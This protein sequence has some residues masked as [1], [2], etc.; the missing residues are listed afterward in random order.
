MRENPENEPVFPNPFRTGRVGSAWDAQDAVNDVTSIHQ[1]V[2]DACLD[3][4]DHVRR[5]N[6][7]SGFLMS[8][9]PGSGKTHMIRRLRE[10]L[11]AHLSE[12]DLSELKQIFAYVR[13]D[14]TAQGIARHVRSRVAGDLLRKSER[15]ASPFELMVIARLM[16]MEGSDG[17]L[18]HWW[19]YLLDT[20][21]RDIDEL[22]TDF[23][24]AAG[25]TSNFTRILIHLVRR[26]HRLD[27]AAWL[28]G[29]SLSQQAY[30]RLEIAPA[31]DDDAENEALGVLRDFTRLAGSKLPLVLCFDQVEALQTR[32]DDQQAVFA[33]G[34]LICN[35]H[36]AN[37]NLVIISCM[38]SSLF[39]QFC[40]VMPRYQLD[41]V[42][43]YRAMSL[44]PLREAEARRLLVT[45]LGSMRSVAG[46]P[47]HD[48][49]LWPLET[50]DLRDLVGELGT[51]PRELLHKAAEAFDARLR[52]RSPATMGSPKVPDID[53]FL[54][55]EWEERFDVS[56]R[57]SVPEKSI[58]ILRNGLGNLMSLE[59]SAWS[60][61]SD[62]VPGVEY[63]FELPNREARVGIALLDNSAYR[64]P[65]QLATIENGQLGDAQLHKLVL[66]RDERLPIGQ[67]ATATRNRIDNLQRNDAVLHWM[68]PEACAALDAANQLLA[69]A[70][71][72]DLSIDGET[73]AADSVVNWLRMNM[74][75]ALKD[76][77][78]VLV[79]SA[80]EEIKSVVVERLQEMIL[81]RSVCS[82]S[83]IARDMDVDV[84]DVEHAVSN[85]PDL[86]GIVSGNPAV[87]FSAR[88]GTRCRV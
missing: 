74:P 72:G 41:A 68:A 75:S 35:L 51:T 49:E 28:R 8:G 58:E 30:G 84:S 13:L 60:V 38:Q 83:E 44:N 1:D 4:I 47:E 87:I 22:L 25:L 34:Q 12:P 16:D 82:L 17:D 26:R 18:L 24:E 70:R 29:E 45:R 5:C 85:R 36:D 77:I 31:P 46:W 2:F 57:D 9:A 6:S 78:D 50:R 76:T 64:L 66:L 79:S 10:R 14:T 27:V 23:G 52:G 54:N 81:S 69:A 48:D 43:S 7:S 63:V 73:V 62:H 11:T 40:A 3:A 39:E 80:G 53:A 59:D 88:L 65:G 55:H 86:F 19:T 42:Q 37:T 33:Y 32:A 56:L 21:S 67:T 20:R 71:A 15:G 61:S